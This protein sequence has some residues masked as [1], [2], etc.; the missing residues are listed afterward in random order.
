MRRKV[1]VSQSRANGED[2]HNISHNVYYVKLRMAIRRVGNRFV[3]CLS[4]SHN[5]PSFL[6]HISILLGPNALSQNDGTQRSIP[7]AMPWIR[8]LIAFHMEP[9]VS[10]GIRV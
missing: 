5:S 6:D 10:T 4:F 9:I 8:S 3:S 2:C 7:R 1:Q